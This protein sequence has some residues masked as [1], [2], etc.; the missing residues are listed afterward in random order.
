LNI[1]VFSPSGAVDPERLARGIATL[2]SQGHRVVQAPDVAGQWRYFSGTDQTRLDNF[3]RMLADPSI[4]LMIMSR[5]GYGWSRLL[6]RIKWGAVR[7]SQK[8]IMGFSD[9]TAFQ[10]GALSLANIVTFTGPGVA[11]DFDWSDSAPQTVADHEFMN[12]HCWPVVRGKTLSTDTFLSDRPYP[13]LTISGPIW[14]S[15]LS[16][17][18]HLVGTPYLPAIDRGILFIE[19]IDETPYAIERMFLQLFHNGLLQNQAAVILGDFT[20]CEPEAGRFPYTMAHVIE[21]L[22]E[23]LPC[24]VLTG[25]PFGHVAR[26][27]TLPYGA[28]TTLSIDGD[29]YSLV[30]HGA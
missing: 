19:E 10:M 27:L 20:H 7:D 15:N 9:F 23:W 13:A 6:H 26:K 29:R 25:L 22:R 30:L 12:A 16:L 11:T 3:H 28:W 24:P 21:S 5:G 2:E 4:D 14:G 18:S 1:G 17:L 8:A